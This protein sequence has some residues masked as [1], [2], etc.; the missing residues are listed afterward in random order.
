[1]AREAEAAPRDKTSARDPLA[2]PKREEGRGKEVHHLYPV[3][4]RSEMKEQLT[5]KQKNIQQIPFRL[6]INDHKMMKKL[7]AD[8]GLSF[9]TFVEHCVQ[10]YIG[11]DPTL[12]K[13]IKQWKDLSSIPREA[14][15]Q[16]SLSRRERQSL[17]DEI[18]GTP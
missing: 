9:Q 1:V 18:E 7:L 5:E 17:L 13:M 6:H 8:D 3:V 11:G 10:A 2:S 14:R 16:Y 4:T 15:D 12:I